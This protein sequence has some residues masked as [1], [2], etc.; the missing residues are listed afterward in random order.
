MLGRLERWL[1]GMSKHKSRRNLYEW[2][3]QTVDLHHLDQAKSV[4]NIGAGGE[5]A[6]LLR[7]LGVRTTS[8]DIDPARQPDRIMNVEDLGQIPDASIEA[9]FC[10]DVL[11]HVIRPDVA[12]REI[13]RVLRPGG[14][15]V[16]STP[17]L[18][19]IHD[20]PAD[21]WRFTRHGLERLFPGMEILALRERNGYFAATAVLLT[22]CFVKGT[23][24]RRRIALVL[25][26]AILALA[27][28]IELLDRWMPSDEATTG[29]FFVLRRPAA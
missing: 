28:C 2:I 10:C 13:H 11:E 21:F 20:A 1:Y 9:I 24:A 5:V 23:R 3:A 18:L 26:P 15:L 8:I 25:S 4:L 7:R 6:D 29:Y 12:T 19:G 27:A 22:R 17:F 16:G 14:L